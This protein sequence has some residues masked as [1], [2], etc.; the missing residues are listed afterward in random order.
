LQRV[1]NLLGFSDWQ[2]SETDMLNQEFNVASTDETGARLGG[3]ID[4]LAT[5]NGR[6]HLAIIETKTVASEEDLSQLHWYVDNCRE[7]AKADHVRLGAV[8]FARTV[9][10]LLAHEFLPGDYRKG[11]RHIHL[12]RFRFDGRRF[13]FE[14]PAVIPP[15]R[16]EDTPVVVKHSRFNT[17]QEHRG[18]LSADLHAAFDE[19][20]R[21][22][23]EPGDRRL[24][25]VVENVKGDHIAIHYKGIYV[26]YLQVRTKWF[27]V[28]YEWPNGGRAEKVGIA[29]QTRVL[30]QARTD[31]PFLLQSID[32]QDE[33]RGI[34][35]YFD[36]DDCDEE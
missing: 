22:C 2:S 14:A 23:L 29:E 28:G 16:A 32:A 19:L 26:L 9:G 20:R 11:D 3:R 4:V 13:P 24:S 17:L 8:D 34:P 25:W 6:R 18:W 5:F 12:V 15:R 1:I 35:S 31:L 7:I 30:E 27:H 10:I 33:V 21:L 36:W